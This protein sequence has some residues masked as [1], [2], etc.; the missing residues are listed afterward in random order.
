MNDIQIGDV[1]EY[2]N[3]DKY[4]K[5]LK[6]HGE[7]IMLVT[8]LYLQDLKVEITWFSLE[9]RYSRYSFFK[10]KRLIAD[11]DHHSNITSRNRKAVNP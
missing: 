5:S 4:G 9:S 8:D 2:T 6:N 3:L 1:L 10:E 7:W 11:I